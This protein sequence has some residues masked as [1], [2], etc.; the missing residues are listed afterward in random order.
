MVVPAATSPV[1]LVVNGM[2]PSHRRK[3]ANSGMVT[4]IRAED[5]P[6]SLQ[7]WTICGLEFQQAIEKVVEAGEAV[8]ACEVGGFYLRQT[9]FF[10]A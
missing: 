7:I 1:E 4:E 5:I 8:G 2:S 9:Q 6:K 10:T 3:F